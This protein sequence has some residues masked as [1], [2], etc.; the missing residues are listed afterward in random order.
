LSA[1]LKEEG[2]MTEKREPYQTVLT[3]GWM[4]VKI[5]VHK[6]YV[7]YGEYIE[8]VQYTPY[9]TGKGLAYFGKNLPKSLKTV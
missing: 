9:V 6:E 8:R 3:A 2:Y 7:G 5:G 1:W 4:A